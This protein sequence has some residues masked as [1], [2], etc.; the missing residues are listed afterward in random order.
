MRHR[1]LYVV[2]MADT[3]V[4]AFN[5]DLIDEFRANNG[6]VSGP[7]AGAPLL[8]ITTIGAKSGEERVNPLAYSRDGDRIVIIASKAGAP[9]H[10]DW[11][12]N[13]VANPEVTVELP[14]ETFRAR[15]SVADGEE[16]DRL[17]AERAA[18]TPGFNDYA[19]K[20]GRVIPVVLLTR[21]N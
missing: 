5:R 14:G 2:G 1:V 19:A 16:R 12:H 13:I 11:Y 17:F 10:P 9:T 21:I 15:A 7:M 6:T 18:V 3:D 20:A 8:L 4:N